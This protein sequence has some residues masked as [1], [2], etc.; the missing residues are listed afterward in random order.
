MA[1]TVASGDC[2]KECHNATSCSGGASPRSGALTGGEIL[3]I[4]LRI[5]LLALAGAGG[6][7]HKDR[8]NG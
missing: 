1:L 7:C 4:S 8:H 6:V 5:R 3:G 2:H